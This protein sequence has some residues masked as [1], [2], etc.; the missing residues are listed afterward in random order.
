VKELSEDEQ[1][2]QYV[3]HLDKQMRLIAPVLHFSDDLAALGWH[4]AALAL[5]EAIAPLVKH[6]ELQ[7]DILGYDLETARERYPGPAEPFWARGR[8]QQLKEQ[9]NERA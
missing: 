5:S 7:G 6:M 9:P 8:V 3:K 1:V 2:R 4:D